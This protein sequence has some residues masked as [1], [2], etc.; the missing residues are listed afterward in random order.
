MNKIPSKSGLY[1]TYIYISMQTIPY[2]KEDN[3]LA[4]VPLRLDEFGMAFE[5]LLL[6]I[7]KNIKEIRSNKFPHKTKSAGYSIDEEYRNQTIR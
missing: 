4:S 1:P 6:C 5:H 3:L 2:L 7:I